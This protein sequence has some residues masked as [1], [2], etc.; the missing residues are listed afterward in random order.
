VVKEGLSLLEAGYQSAVMCPP[1]NGRP[2]REEWR[3]I[4]IYR[5]VVLGGARRAIDKLM[6]QAAFWSPAWVRAIREV[7]LEYRPDVLQ[8]HDVWLGR[9]VFLAAQDQKIVMDLH[10]NMPAAVVEYLKGYRGAF[11]WFNA[12]FKSRGRVARYERALLRKADM[13]LVVVEDALR[14]VVSE[15]PDLATGKTVNVENLESKDFLNEKAAVGEVIGRDHFSILYIGGIAPHRGID[16]L[17]AAMKHV[18]AW[19]L[20]VRLHLVGA[21]KSDYLQMLEDLIKRLDVGSHV[22]ITGWVPFESVLAYIRQASVGTVP[23][24]SNPHTN[25]TIPHKLFQYMIAATPVLVSSSPPLAHTVEAARAGLI[26][27]AGDELD[28]ATKIRDMYDA[29]DLLK[30]FAGNGFKYVMEDGHNWEEESAPTLVAAYDRLLQIAPGSVER[31]SA[32]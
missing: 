24:H 21:K 19:G 22:S 7:I 5:P 10:E 26:F 13:V 11:K 32:P 9:S 6:Y 23:H 2:E 16:T 3:G 12:V 28:C 27:L 25:S 20:N 30:R 17:I 18:K 14:R 4:S 1:I 15:C 31:E 8:V 29:P